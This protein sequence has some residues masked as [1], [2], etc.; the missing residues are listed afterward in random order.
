MQVLM[1]KSIS[2]IE[3]IHIVREILKEKE[4][5]GINQLKGQ[6]NSNIIFTKKIE[7]RASIMRMR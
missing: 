4:N 3:I 1:G 6:H 7:R 5:F 2:S